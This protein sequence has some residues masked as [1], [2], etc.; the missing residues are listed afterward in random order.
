VI[1]GG[2]MSFYIRRSEYWD[3]YLAQD[4]AEAILHQINDDERR[5]E[6]FRKYVNT[7]NIELSAFCNRKC[8]YCP[9]ATADRKQEF[10]S[11]DIWN[12]ILDEL[13]EI[14][15][16]G[17]ISFNLFNEPLLDSNLTRRVYEVHK[18]LPKIT[19]KFDSNGDFL[20]REKADE[21]IDAG[22]S[23]ILF[24]HHTENGSFNVDTLQEKILAQICKLGMQ[25]G[26]VSKSCT[27]NRNVT[28]GVNYRGAKLLFC[29]NNWE[30]YGN[31]R[32]G[33]VEILKMKSHRKSPCNN[34]FREVS[35]AYNGSIKPCCNIYFGDGTD[36]GDI[37][38][39]GIIGAYF[40]EKFTEYRRS[41][42]TYGEKTGF[43]E[44]CNTEDNS[45]ELTREF[46]E[47]LVGM[48]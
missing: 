20:T 37:M 39:D 21:V 46:R 30:S 1:L 9:M 40:G 47:N 32:G 41:L 3:Y 24:T 45:N 16:E 48:V 11:E 31:D 43:C 29:A 10:M 15:Y 42:L 27:E 2:K 26:I 38:H 12:K 18:R 25:D 34:P 35:I 17:H 23:F 28:I 7:I 8:S 5:R 14:K 19:L 33:S 6:L 22:V 44:S 13:E 36:V 4:D